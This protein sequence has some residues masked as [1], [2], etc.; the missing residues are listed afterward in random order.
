MGSVVIFILILSLLILVHELGHFFA[1]RKAG[2][3]V[4]EFGFGIPPRLFGKKIGETIYSLNLFPFGGFVR[5]HGE[6]TEDGVV[7]PKRAFINQNKRTRFIIIVAGVFMNLVL[8]ITA[9][10]VS[11]SISGIPR[12]T[13]EVRVVEVAPN[14]PADQ[15]GLVTG[16][17]IKKVNDIDVNSVA[18][19][20]QTVGEKKGEEIIL[21][22]DADGEERVVAMT[23]RVDPPPEEGAVGVVISSIESYFP[24]IWQRP[25]LGIYYGV[26]EALF[27]GGMIFFGLLNLI[28]QLFSGSVPQDIAGPVGIYALTTQ[29]ASFGIVTLI[30]FIGIL[31]INLA[32]LNIFPFPALDGGRLLFIMIEAVLGKKVVPKVEAVAHTVGIIILITLLLA[33]TAND[34]RRLVVGGGIAGFLE[35][36]TQ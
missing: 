29:A 18:G 21:V 10:A 19:F 30:N 25:F 8:A 34:I 35:S 28:K 32:I 5:L 27:W 6:N 17:K 24:P 31:S 11:Y 2:L 12:D 3:L 16:N 7:Q 20:I 1:A 26:K 15:A 14:S 13:G 9:F 36:F 33:V 22:I 23:P 4:E